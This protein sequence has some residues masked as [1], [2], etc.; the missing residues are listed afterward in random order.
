MADWRELVRERL[1][2]L[3]LNVDEKEEVHA[4]IA[5]H[6]EESYESLR[7]K[8]LTDHA[9]MQQVVAQVSDWKILQR[10]VY[11][12]KRGVFLMQNRMRQL[13]V[14]GILTFTLSVFS[15]MA[16][17][18]CG[19][20]PPI[21]WSSTNPI[22]VYVPWLL[23]LPP[24]GALGAY[25]SSRAGGSQGTTSLVSIFPVLALTTTFLLMFPISFL[26]QLVTGVDMDF[27]SVATALLKDG[28]GWFLLPAAALLLGGLIT[29]LLFTSQSSPQQTAIG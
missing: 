7:T 25:L 12:A 21:S 3:A 9:A 1:S 13:W 19:F 15:L 14:P 24:L 16:V 18:T 26:V 8:G 5:A 11:F 2:G 27:G 22:L 17:Q 4:E 10:D 20:R 23:T 29:R 28:I 6:L